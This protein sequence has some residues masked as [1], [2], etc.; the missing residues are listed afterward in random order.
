M[1]S[2]VRKRCV[3][4]GLRLLV[5]DEVTADRPHDAGR[6]RLWHRVPGGPR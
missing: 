1:G 6:G 5:D 3:G 2:Q 4:H